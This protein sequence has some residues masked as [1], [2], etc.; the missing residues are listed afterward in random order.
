LEEHRLRNTDGPRREEVAEYWRKMFSEELCDLYCS[1]YIM[2]KLR[3]RRVR[4]VG[5]VAVIW[6]TVNTYRI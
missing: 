5:Y 6:E 4:L 1:P 3:S 2:K